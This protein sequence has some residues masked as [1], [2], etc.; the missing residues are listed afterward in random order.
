MALDKRNKFVVKTQADGKQ[1]LYIWTPTLAQKEGHRTVSYKEALEIEKRIELQEK[2]RLAHFN[3]M[4]EVDVEDDNPVIEE[5]I[6]ED[7]EVIK[8]KDG[9]KLERTNQ[10]ILD[11]ELAK[12]AKYNSKAQ[13]EEYFLLKYRVGLIDASLKEMKNEASTVLLAFANENKLY[14]TLRD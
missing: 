2:K 1:I 7:P 6:E 14:D 11:D 12:V 3:H 10:E 8:A 13:L 5:V 9:A 4:H